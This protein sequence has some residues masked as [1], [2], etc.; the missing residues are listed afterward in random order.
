MK[1]NQPVTQR[2]Y[3]FPAGA[4]LMSTTDN[5]SH[6]TYANDAF[7]EVSGFT[8][9]EIHGQPHNLVRHPDM[10]Q[11]AFADMWATLK[12][13]EPW[14][15]LVK[16]RRKN[17]DHYWVRANA[18]PV[19]RNGKTTG[20]MSVRTKASREEIAAAERLYQDFR[21]GHAGTRRFHKGLIIRSGV[22]ALK[23]VFQ[24]LSVRSRI[25]SA[26]VATVPGMALG[27]ACVGVSGA[28]LGGVVAVAAALA[29][30]ASLWLEAQIAQPLEEVNAQ[31]LRVVAGEH[32]EL[33][34][35]P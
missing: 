9:E 17:G 20:Y 29:F 32:T 26:L 23:S 8:R 2:E 34:S 15:A 19:V 12:G 35:P 3:E 5:Q 28:A 27:A 18:T 1:I 22:M 24:T 4:T 31:A 16:N 13:G 30:A 14:T 7:I 6:I 21:E 33:H 25:R 11:E 10:P